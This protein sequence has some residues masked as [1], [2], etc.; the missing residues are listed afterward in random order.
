MSS[1]AREST[2]MKYPCTGV[3][4]CILVTEDDTHTILK[5]VPDLNISDDMMVEVNLKGCGMEEIEWKMEGEKTEVEIGERKKIQRK[6][7]LKWESKER[8][9]EERQ[10]WRRENVERKSWK[11]SW[12]RKQERKMKGG[13]GEGERWKEE[14]DGEGDKRGDKER[15]DKGEM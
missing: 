10:R 2:A 8:R 1:V 4:N 6:R 15:K 11:G 12:R 13:D 3:G 14:M 5:V 7:K 9:V